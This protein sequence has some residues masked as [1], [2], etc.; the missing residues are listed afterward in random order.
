M[1]VAIEIKETSMT[2]VPEDRLDTL[3]APELRE[4]LNKYPLS[5]MTE[6]ILD[7]EKLEFISSAGLRVLLHTY[8]NMKMGG[9]LRVINANH[10][11]KEV[12][13]VT[14]FDNMFIIE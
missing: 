6:I 4:E 10:I 7:A 3:T 1:K 11:I 2:L 9:V 5:Q 12:F 14:G 8:R 13:K